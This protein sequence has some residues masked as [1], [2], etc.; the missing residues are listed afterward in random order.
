MIRWVPFKEINAWHLRQIATSLL[1]APE[2]VRPDE[3]DF[4][5]QLAAGSMRL[6]EFDNGIIVVH[7]ENGRL[8]V[9]AMS[10]SIWQRKALA[11]DLRRLA[12]DWLCDTIQTTVFDRRL[13]DGIVKV[14]GRI[15][16]YDLILDAGI[17]DGQQ[18][19]NDD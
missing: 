12:A 4:I 2:P 6:F 3:R 9:D 17:S 8:V 5:Q 19:E 14:G 1:V 18:E 7:T 15:E 16:S 13:A 10:C 11:D